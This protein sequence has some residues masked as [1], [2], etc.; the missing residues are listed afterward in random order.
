MGKSKYGDKEFT[1]EQRLTQ[2]NQ[3]LKREIGRLRK[4]LARV[5]LDRYDQVR[6]IIEE[7]YAE[8]RAE[9]GQQI[10]SNLKQKWKCF[11]CEEGFLE[12]TLFNKINDTWY[13][14]RCNCCGHRTKSQK[15][16]S[17]RVSGILKDEAKS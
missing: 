6:E 1:K 17:N 11:E 10:L 15:Y 13:F 9:E 16:D 2:E 4:I 7:H 14:R 8:E 12:I 3:K 5:D